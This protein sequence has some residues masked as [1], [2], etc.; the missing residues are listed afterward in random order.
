MGVTDETYQ[1]VQRFHQYVERLIDLCNDHGITGW[2]APVLLVA[3]FRAN[4]E[5]ADAWRSI[6]GEIAR[7]E[8]GKLG[9]TTACAIIGLVLGGVGIAAMGGAVGVPLALILV[10]VGY[11]VGQEIDSQGWASRLLDRLRGVRRGNENAP[12]KVEDVDPT[13]QTLADIDSL[14]LVLDGLNARCDAVESSL[15]DLASV[16][17][18]LAG[19][20]S[21]LGELRTCT[22]K[23][24]DRATRLE[25]EI[26]VLCRLVGLLAILW[27]SSTL[28]LL[29]RR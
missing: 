23:V 17:A 21:K 25:R 6:W 29:L 9:L 15:A 11:L 1:T 8:G 10:P 19:A 18:S 12:P 3:R 20:E 14:R 26:R 27:A 4:S 28:W 24:S 13:V 16:R 5:F 2:K 22:Q 7:A